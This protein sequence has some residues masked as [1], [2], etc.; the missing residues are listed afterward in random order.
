MFGAYDLNRLPE[1]AARDLLDPRLNESGGSGGI[2]GQLT[3][4]RRGDRSQFVLAGGGSAREY[5][6]SPGVAV[7][8]YQA[9]ASLTAEIASKLVLEAR[10]GAGYSPFVPFAPSFESGGASVAPSGP[11][12]GFAAAAERNIVMNASLGLTSNVTKRTSMFATASAGDSWMLD[13]P[14]GNLGTWGGP[15]AL[16][17]ASAIAWA[18]GSGCIS[19]T[20]RTATSTRRLIRHPT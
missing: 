20:A 18:G 10:G 8:A 14:A 15:G 17:P 5:A 1:P 11:A 13:A 4:D 19:S 3:Y 2:S 9:G 7:L 12:F 16:A 6:S